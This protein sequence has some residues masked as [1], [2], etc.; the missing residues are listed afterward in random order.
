MM[1]NYKNLRNYESVQANDIN[2]N[3]S[4]ARVNS[5]Q[6]EGGGGRDVLLSRNQKFYQN[7]FIII[8]LSFALI[9]SG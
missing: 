5:T 7:L 8:G 9:T 1:Y 2:F 4:F 6:W 3:K